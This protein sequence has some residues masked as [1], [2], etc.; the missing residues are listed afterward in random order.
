MDVN[1]LLIVDVNCTLIFF[2]FNH[3]FIKYFF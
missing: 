3:H 2:N 1:I